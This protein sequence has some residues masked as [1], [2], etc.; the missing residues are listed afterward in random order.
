MSALGQSRRF[1]LLT[2]M[3]GLPPTA[4]ISGQG[5]HFSIVPE[6]DMSSAGCHN[7]NNPV[8]AG[9]PEAG[10]CISA[11]KAAWLQAVFDFFSGPVRL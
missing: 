11:G 4:D 2:I 3:S 10:A 8:A 1:A 9:F 5:W 6:A 7:Q